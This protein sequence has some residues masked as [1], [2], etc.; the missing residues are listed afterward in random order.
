MEA[1]TCDT[2][3]WGR[4]CAEYVSGSVE[5]VGFEHKNGT[6]FV[7][8]VTCTGSEW[9]LHSGWTGNISQSDAGIVAKSYCEGRGSMFQKV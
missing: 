7:G 6:W 2:H 1:A 8:D 3:D 4:V 5:R 9:I